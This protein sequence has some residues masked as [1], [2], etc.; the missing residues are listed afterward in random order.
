MV[1]FWWLKVAPRTLIY[2]QGF[3]SVVYQLYMQSIVGC[4]LSQSG[5]GKLLLTSEEYAV[6]LRV[7]CCRRICI[8]LPTDRSGTGRW[9]IYVMDPL[10]GD[11]LQSCV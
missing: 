10:T 8:S 2:K 4:W 9:Y 6:H 7:V 5:G 3:G 1:K 11:R